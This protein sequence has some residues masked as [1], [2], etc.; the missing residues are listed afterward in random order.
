MCLKKMPSKQ[1]AFVDWS[2]DLT[3]VAMNQWE[4]SVKA[5]LVMI[6]ISNM[7]VMEREINSVLARD[8]GRRTQAQ[9][10]LSNHS[11]GGY[12]VKNLRLFESQLNEELQKV[13]KDVSIKTLSTDLRE[14]VDVASIT[15]IS[16]TTVVVLFVVAYIYFIR[17]RIR[18]SSRKTLKHG[19]GEAL[20]TGSV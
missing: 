17:L 19:E 3:D 10:M 16:V 14:P 12:I 6:L 7:R 5:D 4:S 18:S 2:F 20:L 13:M 11:G 1:T 15:Q 8:H 9:C